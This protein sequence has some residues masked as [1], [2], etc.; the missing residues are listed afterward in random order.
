MKTKLRLLLAIALLSGI[1]AKAEYAKESSWE[2]RG[3][4]I[5]LLPGQDDVWDVAGGGTLSIIRWMPENIGVGLTLG[6]QTWSKKDEELF[7][8]LYYDYL[9]VTT[10]GSAFVLPVGLS[11]FYRGEPSSTFSYN[12]EAGMQYQFVESDIT[13]TAESYRLYGESDVDIENGIT[14]QIAGDLTLQLSDGLGLFLGAGYQFDV[15]KGKISVDGYD[16]MDNELAGAFVRA[17][18][19]SRF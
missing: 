7:I 15:A 19:T 8:N 11:L 12:L 4:G 17:G 5:V 1:A 10:E 16:L 3:G 13:M 9:Y 14:A 2:T 18:L 6:G